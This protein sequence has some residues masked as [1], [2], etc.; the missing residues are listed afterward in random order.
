MGWEGNGTAPVRGVDQLGN[1]ENEGVGK[2]FCLS[3]ASTRLSE[4]N[5]YTY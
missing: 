5:C 3:P 2:C 4:L 1:M